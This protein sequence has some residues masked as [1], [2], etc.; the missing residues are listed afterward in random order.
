MPITFT[1]VPQ[2][3]EPQ[4]TR[5][6][7]SVLLDTSLLVQNVCRKGRLLRQL[8]SINGD[9]STTTLHA[10]HSRTSSLLS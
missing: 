1:S 5:Y 6:I 8:P 2:Q 7:Q 9:H 3:F 10:D 4:R